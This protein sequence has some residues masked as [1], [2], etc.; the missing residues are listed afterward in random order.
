MTGDKRQLA[1]TIRSVATPEVVARWEPP[2]VHSGI[3]G[4][5]RTQQGTVA[6]RPAAGGDQQ[7]LSDPLNAHVFP[8]G[9]S[10]DG[11]SVLV[12]S[13]LSTLSTGRSMAV[14]LWPLG[15]APSRQGRTCRRLQ[16]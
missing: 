4:R 6:V 3:A 13:D 8:F 9:W 11:Q 2:G 15:A 7:L 12:G 5:A 1:R 10:P 16:S 14:A